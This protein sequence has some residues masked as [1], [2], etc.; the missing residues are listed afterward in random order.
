MSDIDYQKQI[1][2][3]ISFIDQETEERVKEMRA[4]TDEQACLQ[5]SDDML[6]ARQTIDK[7]YRKM[8]QMLQ[9]SVARAQSLEITKSRKWVSEVLHDHVSKIKSEAAERLIATTHPSDAYN[10]LLKTLILQAIFMLNEKQ[11]SCFIFT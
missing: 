5:K 8:E 6:A 3:M 10:K 9:L 11:V 2:R 1:T 4:K 7:Q